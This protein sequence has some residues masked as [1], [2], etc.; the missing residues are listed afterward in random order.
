MN[1]LSNKIVD[2]LINLIKFKESKDLMNSYKELQ[3]KSK[4]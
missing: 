2:L 4:I 3:R 1:F